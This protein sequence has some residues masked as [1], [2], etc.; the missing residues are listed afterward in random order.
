[1]ILLGYFDQAYYA[2]VAE[3]KI[4]FLM[5]L[6]NPQKS[7]F[8]HITKR[9]VTVGDYSLQIYEK[10]PKNVKISKNFG[11]KN[12]FRFFSICAFLIAQTK[13]LSPGSS[14]INFFLF[15][16]ACQDAVQYEVLFLN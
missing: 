3:N 5:K 10:I 11:S 16:R 9:Y 15:E 4:A 7:L 6:S 12:V 8:I 2:Y 13:Y 1:L 14:Y